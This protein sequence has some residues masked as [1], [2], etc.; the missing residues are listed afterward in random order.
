METHWGYIV[1]M[2]GIQHLICFSSKL[3]LHL[4]CWFWFLFIHWIKTKSHQWEDENIFFYAAFLKIQSFYVN[5][6]FSEAQFNFLSFSW[7]VWFIHC[8][9]DLSINGFLSFFFGGSYGY[10]ASPRAVVHDLKFCTK[11]W[12]VVT[13]SWCIF[14]SSDILSSFVH[15]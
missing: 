2:R 3:Q 4:K 9:V 6:L 10:T 7:W 13:H 14:K 5:G 11:K 8:F 15:V 1:W 12:T